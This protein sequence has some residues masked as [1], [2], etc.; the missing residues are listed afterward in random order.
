[1]T[2]LAPWNSNDETALPF[3][4]PTRESHK[5]NWE[6]DLTAPSGNFGGQVQTTA[7]RLCCESA[8]TCT[9]SIDW[10]RGSIASSFAYAG[11]QRTSSPR[12]ISCSRSIS[13]RSSNVSPTRVDSSRPV[14]QLKFRHRTT[15]P[16]W[17][18]GTTAC[19]STGTRID[20][21]V[22]GASGFKRSSVSTIV[23]SPRSSQTPEPSSSG[24]VDDKAGQ[25]SNDHGPFNRMTCVPNFAA[26]LRAASVHR[27]QHRQ[28]RRRFGRPD[29]R[30]SQRQTATIQERTSERRRPVGP[31]EC[32]FRSCGTSP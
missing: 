4:M 30:A 13:G 5:P 31:D 3:A 17:F 16:T 32:P 6:S 15:R 14:G 28:P 11:H 19:K 9:M 23:P 8:D 22:A 27:G 29:T 26:P 18:C 20:R 12:R 1:M 10:C 24:R 7:S 25:N 21:G 2:R